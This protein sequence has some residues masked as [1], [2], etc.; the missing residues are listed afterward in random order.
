MIKNIINLINESNEIK[1]HRIR[2]EVFALTKDHKQIL[3]HL[4]KPGII[5]KL[6]AGGVDI[7]ETIINAAKREMM[8]ESGWIAE[9]FKELKVPGNW[10]MNF[11]KKQQKEFF[12]KWKLENGEIKSETNHCIVCNPITFTPSNLY[13]SEGDGDE[14]DLYDTDLIYNLTKNS[15]PLNSRVEFQKQFRLACFK[16]S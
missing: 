3:A 14:F 8:E 7:G 10:T 4:R 11:T 2:V 13:G 1:E 16:L 5:P 9:N 15:T 12:S 6:P